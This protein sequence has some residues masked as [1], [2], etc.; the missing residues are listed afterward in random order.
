MSNDFRPWESGKTQKK[1]VTTAVAGAAVP[2]SIA[3]WI[4]SVMRTTDKAPWPP[5]WDAKVAGGLAAALAYLIAYVKDRFSHK[6]F[7]SLLTAEQR[8]AQ[9]AFYNKVTAAGK[10]ARKER[11]AN[12]SEVD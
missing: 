5:E 12:K 7:Q 2:I 8:A 6:G 10:A 3:A 9:T 1:A 4:V 11:D